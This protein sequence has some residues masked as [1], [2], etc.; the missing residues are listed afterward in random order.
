MQVCLQVPAKAHWE[1]PVEIDLPV[2]KSIVNRLMILQALSGEYPDAFGATA[3]DSVLMKKLLQTYRQKNT[4]D[5][6][7]AGTV[8]RF[9][10]AFLASREGNWIIQGTPRMH[11]RP[12]AGL[13]DALQQMGAHIEYRGRDGYLPIA[14]EGKELKGGDIWIDASVSSQYISAILLIA[15]FLKQALHLHLTN[16]P[17]SFPYVEMTIRILQS[18]GIEVEY[19]SR[20]IR[21]H[22]APLSGD[23]KQM[24]ENDWSA[25]A[26]WYAF[27]AMSDNPNLNIKFR[28]LYDDSLQGDRLVAGYFSR[29]GVKT[30]FNGGCVEIRKKEIREKE[31]EFDFLHT[32]DLAQAVIVTIAAK[33]WRGRFTGLQSLRLKETDR[34]RAL[35]KE[36]QKFRVAVTP[37]QGGELSVDG[38]YFQA[39][40]GKTIAV[41]EDHRMAMAFAP[42]TLKT[43]SLIIEDPKVVRKSY[44]EFWKE[45]AKL[46]SVNIHS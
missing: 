37:G 41:Y 36:L 20:E 4:V 11:R 7:D 34:I 14:I 22:P 21:V 27:V 42:L 39:S 43:G 24:I 5:V 13:I 9:L 17:V 30:I 38:T 12:I 46:L 32:P 40:P 2:S 19:N 28:R 6:E 18:L 29:L 3:H 45:A 31:F 16:M 44:P 1:S 33:G 8:A 15:P 35:Q 23:I 26:F 25:A 10:T